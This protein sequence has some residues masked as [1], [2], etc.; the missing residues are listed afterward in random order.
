MRR[1]LLTGWI[2]VFCIF[3]V[4]PG[5]ERQVQAAVLSS[6]SSPSAQAVQIIRDR[7]GVP[8]IFGR[9]DAD[10]FYG[11]GYITAEDRG[12][13]MCLNRRIIQGRLA[14]TVGLV[15]R[16]R[17]NQTSLDYDLR[18]RTFGFYRAAQQVVQALDSETLQM[19]Q[20][21]CDGVNA[22]FAQNRDRWNPMF[23]KL[24]FRP[25]PWTPADCIAVWWHM[26]QFFASDGTR[27]WIAL[28]NARRGG[29]FGRGGR[30]L[31]G[32]RSGRTG[33]RRP[34][35]QN[36]PAADDE[37]AVIQR[38]DVSETW[39]RRVL[40]FAR[41][42]HLSPAGGAKIGQVHFSHA[43]VVGGK[44]TTTGAAV[45]VS[46]PQTLVRNPSMFYEWHL[47]GATFNVRGIGV[48]G[49]PM[50]LI[51]FTSYVAWGLTALGADQADLFLLKTDPDHPNQ[52]WFDGRW[53][54][55]QV[56]EEVFRVRG[57][58][59][60]RKQIRWTRFGPVVNDLVLGK[61]R[62]VLVV[63]KRIPICETDRETIQAAL[64]MWR[65]QNAKEFH[66]ALRLW[67]FPSANIVFGDR[68]GHIGYRVLG[69][70]PLRSPN[71]PSHGQMAH[72]VRTQED[73][74]QGF[75]PFDLLPH[76]LDPKSGILFSA[77]HRPIGSWYPIPIGLRT[78]GGGD[79]VRS[80]RLRERLSAK[81]KFTPKDVLDVHYDAVNPARRTIVQLALWL[82]DHQSV[83]WNTNELRAL[84]ILERWYKEGAKSDLRCPGAALAM[85]LDTFFRISATPLAAIYGGGE[86]GLAYF[87]KTVS[88][89]LATDSKARLKPMEIAFLRH[90]LQT[91]WER[92][93]RK[94]GP[95]P[96]QWNRKALQMIMRRRMG[97]CDSLDGFPGV[98]S[99]YAL[100]VPAL[101]RVDGG[102]I[103]S[104]LSES[105]TQ[106][107]PLD[108]PDRA[109][110]LLPIGASERPDSPWR[111]NRIEMWQKGKLYP[112]PLSREAV[113]RWKAE[114][115]PVPPRRK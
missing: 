11:L 69:A 9:T 30:G 1:V 7:W 70:F 42:H 101:T 53:W 96:K 54:P 20:A 24:G 95:D 22:W 34:F 27:D 13:Q 97:Y 80:W 31:P 36:R 37:A 74:W 94:Y 28:Q 44:K 72:W 76:V 41:K 84:Q 105:Y 93:V 111:T 4:F 38:E 21:Y 52:Y 83:S 110:A 47:V 103:A 57:G 8:H 78:G 3:S 92:A 85:E 107:V 63:L 23:Q 89:R 51:G 5:V 81:K 71:D 50:I 68:E 100:S 99:E 73:D 56:R 82:R 77:N 39:L 59:P 112:A 14:E 2:A 108:D 79:T 67:R 35:L 104:Q 61:P 60:V 26:G 58:R 109:K 87:L 98:D 12:F 91:G 49:S 18:M 62:G 88:K 16:S 46:D 114:E 86:S 106:W 66:Q 45:L 65:A 33:S 19:L 25:E 115:I 113:L 10:A 17:R 102:T 64:P 32:G 55:V 40:D 15:R 6:G 75:V 43:W 29:S 90:S 48:P